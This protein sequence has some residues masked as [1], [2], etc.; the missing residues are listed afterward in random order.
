M[1]DIY[2]TPEYRQIYAACWTD[3]GDSTGWNALRDWLREHDIPDVIIEEA[4]PK[5]R[6]G[7][8]DVIRFFCRGIGI[9]SGIGSGLGSGRGSG[10]GSGLGS[11]RGSG[12]GSGLGSGQGSG[13]GLGLGLGSIIQSE[14]IQMEPGKAY[15]VHLGDWHTFVGRCVKQT[16]PS[17]YLFESVSKIHDTNRGDNWEDLA[18]DANEARIAATYRHYS[19]PASV[20]LSIIAFEWKGKTPQ[21]ERETESK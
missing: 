15:L 3:I 16:G 19:T 13:S 20:P 21:E 11:G 6:F 7:P 17:T 5:L 18:A 14:V 2:Q 1:S 10:S 8:F 12:S 4:E 9:G